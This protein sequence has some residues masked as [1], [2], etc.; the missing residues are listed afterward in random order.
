M[1][2]CVINELNQPWR[3]H[4]SPRYPFIFPFQLEEQ[5]YGEEIQP[6]SIRG[7]LAEYK[8]FSEK[9]TLV[10]KTVV[11]DETSQGEMTQGVT[12]LQELTTELD[13]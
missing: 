5:D 13:V 6:S 10:L 3:E 1:K 9:I 2:V 8:N 12:D 4:G 7:Y 11:S